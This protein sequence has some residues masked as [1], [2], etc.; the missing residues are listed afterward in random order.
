MSASAGSAVPI[1]WDDLV[2]KMK[3][4]NQYLTSIS[5]APKRTV[6]SLRSATTEK[7]RGFADSRA[8]EASKSDSVAIIATAKALN[9]DSDILDELTNS[10]LSIVRTGLQLALYVADK[11]AEASGF[12]T[13]KERKAASRGVFPDDAEWAA[14]QETHAAITAF[15]LA[16][17][18][19]F[20]FE[21]KDEKKVTAEVDFAGLPEPVAVGNQIRS[22]GYLLYN[23]GSYL[24][25]AQTGAQLHRLTQLYFAAVLKE[26]QSRSEAFKFS[27]PFTG[28][29]YQFDST[30][31]IIRGFQASILGGAVVEFKRVELK[32]VVGNHEAKRI[33]ARLAQMTIAYDFQRKMNPMMELDAF[34]WLGVLQGSAGT[35]KSMLLGVLQTLVQDH[36]KALGLPFQLRPIPN[37]IISS[38]QG[39]SARAYEQWWQSTFDPNFITVAPVDDAEAVYL[40]RRSQ[41]SSEGSKLVVM[42]H[43]RLTEGST[44]VNAGNVLQAHATNN[45][46]MIDPPVFSRYL[47]RIRVPG[48]ETRND[49]LDQTRMWGDK[50]NKIT[51]PKN[52]LIRLEF[53][54]DYAFL[55]D[56]GLISREERDRKAE[57]FAG[58]K[59]KGLAQIW[60]QVERKR[61]SSNSYDLYGTFF[62]E[63][64][65]R[66]EN[67]T[68]RDVRNVTTCVTSRLFGFD[69]PPEWL[70]DC[71]A[72]VAKD[73]DTK[74]QMILEAALSYQKGLTVA[75]VIFQE[76]VNYVESTIAMLDSG[77]KY[78]I[79]QLADENL[80]RREA[81][82]LAESEWTAHNKAPERVAAE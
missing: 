28:T 13:L 58:F 15:V 65:K 50:V 44:A 48:A 49:F 16:Y 79:R 6:A 70:S 34:P 74:K 37:A 81:L 42:A 69:F 26:M 63:L 27:E 20:R 67:F 60:E 54:G 39:E 12:A 21:S 64:H 61:L 38:L 22:I 51:D 57:S 25:G 80:E 66:F 47:Y 45:A 55:S 46:D 8:D 9:G 19:T 10:A 43:L 40:D 71:E 72:F 11:Y 5:Y 32:Q 73:Y 36:C 75:Q 29:T 31:F 14:K 56:Q 30:G 4:A 17:Y 62:A 77:R 2:S 3:L 18:V 59:D 78:R 68:S 41:S 33:V 24:K 7:T 1:S 52:P 23:W 82:E 76:M 35:G 53:P